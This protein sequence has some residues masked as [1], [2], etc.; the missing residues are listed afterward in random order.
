VSAAD[1]A[2]GPGPP[3]VGDVAFPLALRGYDREA[4]DAYVERV[5]GLVAD[6]EASR[7]PEDAVRRALDEVGEETSSILQ[8]A[9]ETASEITARSRAQADDRLREAEREARELTVRAEERVR[10]LEADY[11]RIWHERD[12]LLEEV[13]QLAE[14]L[15]AT[16]D[17][18]E[19]RWARRETAEAAQRPS[20]GGD[21]AS[22]PAV[23]ADDVTRSEGGPEAIGE[24]AMAVARSGEADSRGEVGVDHPVEDEIDFVEVYDHEADFVDSRA[25]AG[26]EEPPPSAD[27]SPSTAAEEE[28][29]PSAGRPAEAPAPEQSPPR[30]L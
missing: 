10:A 28:G 13:R 25:H 8:R 15:L 11:G 19:D 6:L 2:E 24:D 27:G 29:E 22:L 7:S 5:S 20:G 12:L 17:D 23:A 18:A 30:S 26:P 4:V 9:R 3:D 14:R 21:T 1:R 16:A